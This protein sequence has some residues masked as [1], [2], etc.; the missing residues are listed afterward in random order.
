MWPFSPA[1]LPAG[2]ASAHRTPLHP[3]FGRV[4]LAEQEPKSTTHLRQT[5]NF[6]KGQIEKK[7]AVASESQRSCPAHGSTARPE[8]LAGQASQNLPTDGALFLGMCFP[9]SRLPAKGYQHLS[10]IR[11]LGLYLL[12][13]SGCANPFL[14]FGLGRGALSIPEKDKGIREGQGAENSLATLIESS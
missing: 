7:S 2:T 12:F 3:S 6:Q 5:L 11:S 1:A 8:R 14:C 13:H 10:K 9:G 4:P